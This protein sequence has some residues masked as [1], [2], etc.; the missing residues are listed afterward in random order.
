MKNFIVIVV[1]LICT[2]YLKGQTASQPL[3]LPNFIIE[4]KEQIDVQ[5]GTKQTPY[6]PTYLER[7][8][9]DSL[10]LVEKPRNYII[11]PVKYPETIIGRKFPAGF[12]SASLGSFLTANLNFGYS[13]N[14][15]D[16]DIFSYG[17]FRTSR[18]H[19]ENAGY[20]KL[21][22]GAQSE[23]LAPE[24]FYIF[25]GSKTTTN[26]SFEYIDYKLYAIS[27]APGRNQMNFDVKIVSDGNFEGFDFRTGGILNLFHQG[28][29]G[30]DLNENT[31][32]GFLEIL[33]FEQN[34]HFGGKITID[35]RSLEGNSAN[36]F[37]V[38]GFYKFEYNQT[39]IRPEIGVQL[40]RSTKGNSR[41]M[42]L[43]GLGFKKSLNE[44]IEFFGNFS[45]KLKNK[46]FTQFAFENPYLSDTNF[47]DF[48]NL[49]E[50]S[51]NLKFQP[52]R[53]HTTT[54]GAKFI[55]AKRYPV[56]SNSTIETFRI[57]YLDATFFQIY[58]EGYRIVP[59]IGDFSG[60]IDL[61]IST[62]TSNKKEVPY[63]PLIKV[64][65]DFRRKFFEKVFWNAFAEY[66]G[67]RYAD[68]ENQIQLD[69]YNNIGFLIEYSI[70][71]LWFASF[72]IQNL[73]NS[74]VMV[75]NNYK[76]RGLNFKF[77]LTYKF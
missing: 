31:I 69:A 7:G 36:F 67:K 40:A 21:K 1:L 56:F 61:N 52:T 70:S 34:N 49:S 42:V 64:R 3:E 14:F 59:S 28:T 17:E 18:G 71:H 45:N 35:L 41:P 63:T 65:L 57:D 44:S 9:I 60:R 24:K 11:F 20:T 5:I 19:L 8:A 72:E 29:S 39:D 6:F 47:L 22:L 76:E 77:N 33:K 26:L 37:E 73:L 75:W 13:T 32:A 54:F 16:Y 62:L 74:N 4:G 43:V 27:K 12:L 30:N 10:I 25:G 38:S 51:G 15:Q 23:Y 66:I 46:S 55:Y 50:I 68:T 2:F 48:T 58:A 53:N